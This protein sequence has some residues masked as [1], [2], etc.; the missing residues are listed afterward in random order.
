MALRHLDSAPKEEEFTPLQEHQEQTPSTFFGSKP[1]LY[2]HYSNLTLAISTSGLQLDPAIAKFA[3]SA[4]EQAAEGDSLIRDVDIWVSSR[5]VTLFQQTPAATGVSITYPQI[6]LHA[7]MKYKS[8]IEALLMKL[9]L[10]DIETVNSEEEIE[11]LDIVVLPPNF[12]S[13]PDTTCIK[14]I[15]TAMNACADLHPDPD[16]S[17][18][19]DQEDETAPG[20]TGWITADNMGEY[21]D[22]DGNFKGHIYGDAEESEQ[23]GPGA[24]TVRPREEEADEHTNGVNG[25]D[26]ETKW[27]RTG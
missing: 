10:T 15:F 22:E 13:E 24:G 2:A 6:S 25:E 14:E 5:D 7:T 20:A 16:D 21:L 23:L 11:T 18:E 4:D 19:G 8:Q 1:V 17:E 26:G 9:C 12:A 27:Q 3:A